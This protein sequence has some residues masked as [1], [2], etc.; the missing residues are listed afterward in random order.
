MKAFATRSLPSFLLTLLLSLSTLA[1][2]QGVFD[3]QVVL[4]P[5]HITG[6]LDCTPMH[7]HSIRGNG[8]SWVGVKTVCMPGSPT[9]PP[10][11]TE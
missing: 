9:A 5:F 1:P 2:A 6:C 3:Y 10:F 7:L 8:S 4:E 11:R